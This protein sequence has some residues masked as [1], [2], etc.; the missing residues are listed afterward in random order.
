MTKYRGRNDGDPRGK[1]KTMMLTTQELPDSE[2]TGRLYWSL[3]RYM[4]RYG[5]RVRDYID[6][7]F[8]NSSYAPEITDGHVFHFGGATVRLEET[9][10]L[11]K[12][13]SV[14]KIELTSNDRLQDVITKIMTPGL[15]TWE[16]KA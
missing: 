14:L 9:R 6:D 16:Y 4:C 15:F 1:Y 7:S 2:D 10:Y 13:T 11:R 8:A 5:V 12:K 3:V